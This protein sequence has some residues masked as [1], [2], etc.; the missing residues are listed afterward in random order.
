M[1]LSLA[2]RSCLRR[3]VSHCL[4]IMLCQ[5]RLS[6]FEEVADEMELDSLRFKKLFD[7]RWLSRRCAS[8]YELGREAAS[9]RQL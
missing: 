7:V 6:A 4:A 5:C 8:V 1:Q 2:V 3:H 9:S